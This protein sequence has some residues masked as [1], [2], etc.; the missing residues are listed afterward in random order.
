[1]AGDSCAGASFLKWCSP[2]LIVPIAFAWEQAKAERERA[3]AAAEQALNR[4]EVFMLDT[5][6]C[7]FSKR[8][9]SVFLSFLAYHYKLIFSFLIIGLDVFFNMAEAAD[10][11]LDPSDILDKITTAYQSTVSDWKPKMQVAAK[12]LLISLGTINLVWRAAQLLFRGNNIADLIWEVVRTITVI[13]FFLWLIGDPKIGDKQLFQSLFDS[14]GELAGKLTG[15]AIAGPSDCVTAGYNAFQKILAATPDFETDGVAGTIANAAIWI[16][17]LLSDLVFGALTMFFWLFTAVQ[18][19]I[20][21]VSFSFLLYGGL[22]LLGLAGT[23]WTRNSAMSYLN[24]V[25]ASAL[26]YFATVAV[27]T[28]SYQVMVKLLDTSVEKAGMD[29]NFADQLLALFSFEIG[30]LACAFITYLLVSKLPDMLANLVSPAGNGIGVSASQGLAAAKL[31]S[32]ATGLTA[33]S[34]AIG[35]AAKSLSAAGAKQ[36]SGAVGG[37]IGAAVGAATGNGAAAGWTAGRAAGMSPTGTKAFQSLANT[38]LGQF[39]GSAG[40]ALQRATGHAKGQFKSDF[41]KMGM[42]EQTATKAAKDANKL[43]QSGTSGYYAARHAVAGRNGISEGR[44]D[45]FLATEAAAKAN[46]GKT[47]AGAG[48]NGVESGSKGNEQ[49]ASMGSQDAGSS[50]IG[51]EDA[52]PK[53]DGGAP[54]ASANPWAGSSGS[55]PVSGDTFNPSPQNGFSD[56]EDPFTSPADR[57]VAG[58]NLNEDWDQRPGNINN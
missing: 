13:G 54:A 1:M 50:R 43:L 57:D 15:T 30:V 7:C 4:G 6:D 24:A 38:K 39:I 36:A 19:V 26:K 9:R 56:H 25:I 27:A 42:D 5:F 8:G 40:S 14:M 33:A 58:S 20:V 18:V 47:G 34:V 17:Y 2:N 31:A 22:L 37:A 44:Y 46:K 53:A 11:P 48:G 29:A 55:G 32:A 10:D 23:E 45:Q 21:N 12:S 49:A 41:M 16:M 35:G 51:N 52:G 28:M 3:T